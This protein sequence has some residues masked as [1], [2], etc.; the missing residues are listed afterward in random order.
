MIDLSY[1][2]YPMLVFDVLTP[3]VQAIP[4]V[5]L[6]VTRLLNPTDPNGSIGITIADWI[7][8]E[9]LI[10]GFQPISGEYTIVVQAMTKNTNAADGE[11]VHYLIADA[12]R[13]LLF[14]D[15]DLRAALSTL[16]VDDESSEH[17]SRWGVL[18]QRF[19][20]NQIGREFVFL[21]ATT[22]YFTTEVAC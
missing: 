16:R 22:L 6:C 7:P 2:P 1:K 8:G 21:S 18:E 9:P 15:L 11:V 12:L 13:R 20:N 4:G 10:G 17:T 3:S 19:A 14:T 5:E